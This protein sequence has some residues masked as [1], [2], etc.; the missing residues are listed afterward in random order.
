[1][2]VT[3]FDFDKELAPVVKELVEGNKQ[4]AVL[5]ITAI[6]TRALTG[7]AIVA[8]FTEEK[9]AKAMANSSE[10]KL[11]QE[12]AQLEKEEQEART[13]EDLKQFLID[14]RTGDLESIKEKQG[15]I[16]RAINIVVNGLSAQM[17]DRFGRLDAKL[18]ADLAQKN[19]SHI[20]GPVHNLPYPRNAEFAGREKELAELHKWFFE[21]NCD[22]AMPVAIAQPVT[23][24]SGL[25]GMGKTQLALEYAY[26][27][28]DNYKG[29]L[30][31]DAEGSTIAEGIAD[32]G[33]TLKVGAPDMPISEQAELVKHF[34]EQSGPWLLILDNVDHVEACLPWLPQLGF[35]QVLITTRDISFPNVRSLELD[36][37]EDSDALRLLLGPRV[38]SIEEQHYSVQLC[39]EFG[40]LTLAIA[41]AGTLIKSGLYLPS[42]LLKEIQQGGIIEW[43]EQAEP[44]AVFQKHPSISRLFSTSLKLL[45]NLPQPEISKAI[46]LVGGWF[47]PVTIEQKLLFTAT[48]ILLDREIATKHGRMA[49]SS[50][51]QTGIIKLE[52]KGSPVFHRLM[53]EYL[54]IQGG[55]EAKVAAIRSLHKLAIELEPRSSGILTLAA[56][57]KHLE[58]G[59][60]YL[61]NNTLRDHFFIGLRLA[62][63]LNR[64]A[65]FE[66]ACDVCNTI[67]TKLSSE[68]DWTANFYI[69]LAEA[70]S[71]KGKNDEAFPYLKKA[72]SIKE[73]T[74]GKL[75]H[76]TA[77]LLLALGKIYHRNDNYEEALKHLH[78]A[79]NIYEHLEE[80][81][82]PQ[83]AFI[84]HEIGQTLYSQG[85]LDESLEYLRKA[86]DTQFSA[87]GENDPDSAATLQAIGQVLKEQRKLKESIKYLKQAFEIQFKTLGWSHP[88]TARSLCDIAHFLRFGEKYDES[89]HYLKQALN[90]V[91]STL[92]SQHPD[93]GV[94]KQTIGQTL[95]LQ[96]EYGEALAYLRNALSIIEP[97]F[98]SEHSNTAQTRHDLALTLREYCEYDE[99]MANFNI[100]LRIFEKIFEKGHPQA[101]NTRFEIGRTLIKMGRCSGETLM[102]AAL[103]QM[104]ATLGTDHP[105][106]VQLESIYLETILC[107]LTL[108]HGAVCMICQER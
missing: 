15:H 80:S 60:T 9:L 105:D 88:E 48:G 21:E 87:T 37:L 63:Y 45:E 104:R 98:G 76:D 4:K 93:A 62:Q 61:D 46:A 92:G 102:A 41:T 97:A 6:L 103:K 54:K 1:V 38:F 42:E 57:E 43:T 85:N 39:E 34:L 69:E 56:S 20:T 95:Y 73:E 30:W 33:K 3:D 32:L 94:I 26:R 19:L 53:G 91:D 44:N 81:Y 64:R 55:E 52:E 22:D 11:T 65:Q 96:G 66:E 106:V 23:S 25:G 70:L 72:L 58:Y 8:S 77:V 17:D 67:L 107:P 71:G 49:L 50:L 51:Q 16:L 5:A 86:L 14:A 31:V 29:L 27:H 10:G 100:A 99:A 59:I 108:I 47:A 7:S 84:L 35:T 83:E 90:I 75:H 40:Y 12:Y 28:K 101:T 74:K 24:V 2:D 13:R 79:L 89:V 82:K 18:D 36:R 68:E 78:S